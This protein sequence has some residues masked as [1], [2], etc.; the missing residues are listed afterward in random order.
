MLYLLQRGSS[1]RKEEI[2]APCANKCAG[3]VDRNPAM[4]LRDA[5]GPVVAVAGAVTV[6]PCRVVPPQPSSGS[7]SAAAAAAVAATTDD[8]DVHASHP[9]LSACS[10][11]YGRE[12][13]SDCTKP[14]P[15]GKKKL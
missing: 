13:K 10:P 8:D 14:T 3:H 1:H 9:Q 6:R 11:R 12:S 5:A 2:L 15:G 4:S 7:T